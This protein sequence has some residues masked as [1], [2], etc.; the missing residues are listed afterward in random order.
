MKPK[1]FILTIFVI[2]TTVDFCHAQDYYINTY[3][4][5]NY[6]NYSL[7]CSDGNFLFARDPVSSSPPVNILIKTTPIGGI[8]WAHKLDSQYSIFR[9]AE[10]ADHGF[11][12]LMF[13]ATYAFPPPTNYYYSAVVRLDLNGNLLWSKKYETSN[14]YPN[15]YF[16]EIIRNADNGFM[17]V[18]GADGTEYDQHDCVVK[19]DESGNI[20]WQKKFCSEHGRTWQI[21]SHDY[22]H[23]LVVAK[24]NTRLILTQ[25]DLAG[26]LLWQKVMV[27]PALSYFMGNLCLKPTS[28]GGYIA[29]DDCSFQGKR[30]CLMKFD[31]PGSLQWLQ[32]YFNTFTSDVAENSDSG[33]SVYG[34]S[35][36]NETPSSMMVRLLVFRTDRYRN[37]RWAKSDTNTMQNGYFSSFMS[38]NAI[39][40]G[41]VL[42]SGISGINLEASLGIA[43]ENFS[44]Y[45]NAVGLSIRD[46]TYSLADS[47]LAYVPGN[48]GFYAV[49]LAMMYHTYSPVTKV[50]C[51]ITAVENRNVPKD[52]EIIPDPVI[53]SAIIRAGAPMQDATLVLYNFS[54]RKV[55]EAFHASGQEYKFSRDGLPDGIYFL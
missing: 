10:A 39:S 6:G 38:A 15:F 22:N 11:L 32:S 13:K 49:T 18:G 12:I 28:D 44:T 45:C 17:L 25:I 5:S 55:F 42:L 51:P 20:L 21:A 26:N 54:G 48:P 34:Q 1:A 50:H 4:L 31:S 41:K 24:Q 33:F 19:C 29:A 52:A 37:L 8:V 53:S 46:T 14:S 9:I 47:S 23:L 2:T 16:T 27:A 40:A 3:D 43:D 30:V 36:F 7:V 35:I